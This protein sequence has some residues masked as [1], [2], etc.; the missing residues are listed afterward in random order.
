MWT[1][2]ILAA[3]GALVIDRLRYGAWLWEGRR[4]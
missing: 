2:L 3:L 1:N 4:P